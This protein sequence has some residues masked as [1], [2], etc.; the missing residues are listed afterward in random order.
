MRDDNNVL[1]RLIVA[2]VSVSIAACSTTGGA[3]LDAPPR[4]ID[5]AF[6]TSEG[7]VVASQLE[8]AD[9]DEQR[10][11][12]LMGRTSLPPDAGMLFVFEDPSTGSFW[13]KDTLVPLSIAF[14]G[15]DGRIHT[16]ERM[17]PCVVD[18]CPGYFA[19]APY[20]YALEMN[21]GWFDR[22]RVEVGD[23]ADVELS[24]S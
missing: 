23:R 10:A 2:L 1:I 9:T 19:D 13:M 7:E 4:A 18:D 12:G 22:H 11:R 6:M 14:W 5:V 20:V 16:I 15:E 8:V 3:T 17:E 21:A 24:D